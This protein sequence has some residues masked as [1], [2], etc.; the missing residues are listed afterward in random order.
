MAEPQKGRGMAVLALLISLIALGFSL[1]SYREA[2]GNTALR[3]K[4]QALQ[5]VVE[6][7]RKATADELARIERAIRPSEAPRQHG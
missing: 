3:E 2:A 7:A 5:G 1:A 6:T 4:V